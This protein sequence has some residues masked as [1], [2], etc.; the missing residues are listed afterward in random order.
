MS[1]AV[2]TTTIMTDSDAVTLSM[3]VV[4]AFHVGIS[5]VLLVTVNAVLLLAG[6]GILQNATTMVARVKAASCTM[7]ICAVAPSEV[8]APS[9]SEMTYLCKIADLS[10][11]P[12]PFNAAVPLDAAALI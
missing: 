12:A 6:N 2:I 10:E 9:E 1:A 7:I 8:A 11:T 4:R 3:P 5:A